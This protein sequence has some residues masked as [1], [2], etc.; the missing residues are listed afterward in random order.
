MNNNLTSPGRGQTGYVPAAKFDLIFQTLVHNMNHFT[1][2]AELDAAAD[3]ST[4]GFMGFMDNI[5]G[6]LTNKPVGKG[7]QTTMLYDVSRR[8]PRAYVHRHKL[9]ERPKEFN[10]EGKFEIKYLIDHIEKL[11]V[12]NAPNEEL[13]VVLCPP[14]GH[15]ES[16]SYTRRRIYLRP[17]HITCDNHFSGDNVLDYAGERG[18]GI[19]QMCR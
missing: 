10:A 17:P 6:R 15:G 3:E 4:W 19:T 18:F 14:S 7:G 16:T 5:G 11:V 2:R 9:H 12:G 13:N 8:Y 1:L